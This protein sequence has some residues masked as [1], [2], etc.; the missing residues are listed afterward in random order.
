MRNKIFFKT[1]LGFLH[2]FR[3]HNVIMIIFNGINE[4]I[5]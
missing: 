3:A 4:C 5:F 2:V 1:I